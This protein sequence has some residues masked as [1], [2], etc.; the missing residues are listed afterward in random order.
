MDRALNLHEI[1]KISGKNSILITY[2]ELQEYD[3]IYDIFID[4]NVD[5]FVLLYQTGDNYGHWCTVFI[6]PFTNGKEIEF[7]DPYGEEIDENLNVMK[8]YYDK[9]SKNSDYIYYPHLT[10]LLLNTPKNIKIHY[11][12]YPHQKYSPKIATCGR[13]VGFRLLH[14]FLTIDDYSDLFGDKHIDNKIVEITDNFL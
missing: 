1:N 2:P 7:Y 12:D 14:D 5:N 4:Y 6:R 9:L 11:N 8:K 13:H 3:N 10:R